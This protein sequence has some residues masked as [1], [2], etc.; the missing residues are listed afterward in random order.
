MFLESQMEFVRW[1][2]TF[3]TPFLDEF[4][5]FLAFFDTLQF[6]FI[7]IPTIWLCHSWKHGLKL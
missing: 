1:V 2:H 7:L 6:F 3:R 5:R 4:F